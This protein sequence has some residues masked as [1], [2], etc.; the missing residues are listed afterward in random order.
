MRKT[1][2]KKRKT[3]TPEKGLLIPNL[4]GLRDRKRPR[5]RNWTGVR[6]GKKN[7]GETSNQNALTKISGVLCSGESFARSPEGEAPFSFQA[8]DYFYFAIAKFPT[9]KKYSRDRGEVPGMRGST[10]RNG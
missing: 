9:N 7:N 5:E 3:G 2:K 4:E 10:E 8:Y 6:D 1:G